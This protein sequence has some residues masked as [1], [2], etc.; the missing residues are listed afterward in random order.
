MPTEPP[1]PLNDADAAFLIRDG[2][3]TARK[4][5][6]ETMNRTNT[7]SIVTDEILNVQEQLFFGNFSQ[8]LLKNQLNPGYVRLDRLGSE[9]FNVYYYSCYLGKVYIPEKAENRKYR[10]IK[11]GN[12]R[13]TRVFNN[14]EDAK[15]FIAHRSEYTIQEN[16]TE[17]TCWIQYL[18]GPYGYDVELIESPDLDAI[19]AIIPHWVKSA[20]KYMRFRKQI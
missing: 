13:P 19:I 11:G 14:I 3:K 17:T 15:D 7:Q 16:I 1:P 6:N 2:Y 5:L 10:V 8:E 12:T 18:D 20:K 9:A 4:K